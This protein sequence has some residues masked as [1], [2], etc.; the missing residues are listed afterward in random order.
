MKK[1]FTEKQFDFA[2]QLVI[3]ASRVETA[4]HSMTRG[5]FKLRKVSNPE[6]EKEIE[7]QSSYIVDALDNLK[8]E[9][10]FD[11]LDCVME[12]GKYYNRMGLLDGFER[13]P[14]NHNMHMARCS[15]A[16]YEIYYDHK[17][18][19][20]FEELKDKNEFDEAH[21]ELANIKVNFDNLDERDR[22]FIMGRMRNCVEKATE[23]RKDPKSF[24][25][26]KEAGRKI[27]MYSAFENLTTSQE[28]EME[29]E[30]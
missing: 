28:K 18:N 19:S 10:R 29:M 14:L 4:R 20:L 12:L 21:E 16:V 17:L 8:G 9:E 15:V 3:S 5:L 6:A 25:Q 1:E 11:M 2:K 26:Y 27:R 7:E 22:R 30:V 13:G 24:E 23:V